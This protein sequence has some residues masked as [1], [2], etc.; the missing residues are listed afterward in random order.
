ML[1][2]IP[3]HV[4]VP[5]ALHNYPIAATFPAKVARP[6]VRERQLAV[7]QQAPVGALRQPSAC[8]RPTLIRFGTCQHGADAADNSRRFPDSAPACPCSFALRAESISPVQDDPV[9]F[10]QC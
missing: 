7:R 2:A 1:I 6:S 5:L 4:A 3:N 10:L 8:M 9:T